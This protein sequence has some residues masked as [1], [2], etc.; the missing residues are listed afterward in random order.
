MET[1]LGLRGV[2]GE[3]DAVSATLQHYSNYGLQP[4]QL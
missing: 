1:T 4:N 2:L 3:E